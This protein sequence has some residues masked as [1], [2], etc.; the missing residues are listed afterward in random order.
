MEH[1]DSTRESADGRLAGRLREMRLERRWS[2]DDLAALTGVS[3]ASL[4]RIENAEVSPTAAVLGR[5]A[6]AHATTVSQ[7]LAGV[8]EE[9]PALVPRDQQRRWTDPETGFTRRLVSPPAPGFACELLSCELT[10][11][12]E[13]DYPLP[14][15]PG[16][17]HHLLLQEGE[18]E[19][20]VDG[21]TYR[22]SP[23]DCIR[24]RLN[25]SSRFRALAARPARYLLVI[26]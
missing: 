16:L 14:P 18:L 26:R 3:R 6:H 1:S 17:E 10:A 12:A 11:G 8:E 15:R 21:V 20:T 24:Y 22:L 25:G 5:L 23:G 13:I 7:L 19:L 4:S 9:A 2:L